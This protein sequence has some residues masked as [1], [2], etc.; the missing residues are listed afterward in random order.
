MIALIA[1]QKQESPPP[2]VIRRPQK[3]VRFA[4]AKVVF[5]CIVTPAFMPIQPFNAW[6]SV[7]LP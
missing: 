4:L 7:G 3:G 1:N 5:D 6:N 2:F